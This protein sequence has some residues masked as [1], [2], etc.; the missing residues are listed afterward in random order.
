[1]IRTIRC[2]L[3]TGALLA[4]LPTTTRVANAAILS[5][6]GAVSEFTAWTTPTWVVG[7][8]HLDTGLDSFQAYDQVNGTTSASARAMVSPL[9]NSLL[10]VYSSASRT[11]PPY[12]GDPTP[13]YM[14]RAGAA[15]R[16]I[17]FLSSAGPMP[18]LRLNFEVDGN[19]SATTYPAGYNQLPESVAEVEFF[20]FDNTQS[21][22]L[23]DG[24]I[25]SG[26]GYDFQG[27][28]HITA[29]AGYS[30]IPAST[31]GWDS[32][33]ISDG[34]FIG[35]F[36]IDTSYD[37]TLGGYGWTAGLFSETFG[38]GGAAVADALHTLTFQSVTLTD[39]TAVPLSDISFDS[40]LQFN[41]AAAPEPSSLAL[42]SLGLIALAGTRLRRR[43]A[44]SAGK[45][46]SRNPPRKPATL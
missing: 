29:S 30:P 9:S 26:G 25:N 37:S 12:E 23:F 38:D 36:H 41:T 20:G 7:D 44:S 35:T 22:G 15:W 18:Q 16:D 24:P 3:I 45:S 31:S 34:H 42:C 40:G 6:Y 13:F 33:T 1:M 11:I 5:S 2:A 43:R 46:S 14:A 27:G 28:N 17:L 21:F 19:L 32:I 4:S 39:G 8:G 10:K